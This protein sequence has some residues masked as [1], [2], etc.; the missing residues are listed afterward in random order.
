MKFKPVLAF[1]LSLFIVL[2]S[3]SKVSAFCGFFVAKANTQLTNSSSRVVI[4]REG[5]RSIFMMANDY[6][7]DVDDF[8][9][10][11][12]VPVVLTEDQVHV[13]DRRN[14]HHYVS[15]QKGD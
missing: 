5:N 6:Q 2:S 3:A 9:M 1:L 11:V 14:R 13:G 12:P 10:V 15:V 7:G 8:A 4:A